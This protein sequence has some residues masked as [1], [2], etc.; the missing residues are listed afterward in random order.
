ML[1]IQGDVWRAKQIA[2]IG[3]WE[4]SPQTLLVYP[5][6]CSQPVL[7]QYPLEQDVGAIRRRLIF[8][9]SRELRKEEGI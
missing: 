6:G 3:H 1:M 9:W 4:D 2:A 7:Y 5:V 8:Q